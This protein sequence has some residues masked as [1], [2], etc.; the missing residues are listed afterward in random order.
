[1]KVPVKSARPLIKRFEIHAGCHQ[2]QDSSP[3]LLEPGDRI[4]R[5]TPRGRIPAQ[6]GPID[7]RPTTPAPRDA[8]LA[9]AAAAVPVLFEEDTVAVFVS[10]PPLSAVMAKIGIT[11]GF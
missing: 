5:E 6:R 9:F 3:H 4:P 11:A 1:M 10:C 2:H 8:T 7:I